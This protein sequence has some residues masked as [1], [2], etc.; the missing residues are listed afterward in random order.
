MPVTIHS[1]YWNR[2]FHWKYTLL[3]SI[4][5]SQES[6]NFN[7]YLQ[8]IYHWVIKKINLNNEII[9]ERLKQPENVLDWS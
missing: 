6:H 5:F 4:H 1:K 9:K 3:A 8:I 2:I 7:T